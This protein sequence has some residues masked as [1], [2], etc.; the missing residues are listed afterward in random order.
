MKK[1]H[2]LFTLFVGLVC[3]ICAD[4]ATANDDNR[5]SIAG[6]TIENFPKMDGSTSTKPLNALIACKLLNFRYEW[7]PNI[8]G[9]WSLQPLQADI[10]EEY[11][12]FFEERIK[13]SQTHGAFMNLIDN[14]VDIILTHRTISPDEQTH[15]DEVGVTLTET[16]VALDAFVFVVNK[17]N[18]IE[19]LTVSQIQDIYTGKI[20]NW[21]QVGGNDTIIRPF[22]RPRNSGSEEV[23]RSLVMNGL[24]IADLPEISEILTMA[25]VFPELRNTENGISYTFNFYKDVMVKVPDEYVP[26]IKINGIFPDENTVKNKIYPFVAQVHVAIRSDLDKNSMAYKL[27]EWLQTEAGKAVITESGYLAERSTDNSISKIDTETVK[28]YPNPV[29]EG[30]YITGLTHSAQVTIL[31]A[32]GSKLLSKQVSA[33]EYINISALPPGLYIVKLCTD[34]GVVQSKILKK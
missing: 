1:N 13:V 15:A 30:F 9:E 31:N 28:I 21:R 25:G 10:P 34:K 4:K 14:N 26:K 22:T 6:L 33:G 12:G 18:P 17:N 27:Y 19:S 24:E 8:V 23:M 7:V 20:T 11:S 32:S 29:S 2:L 3:C 5:S 16:P